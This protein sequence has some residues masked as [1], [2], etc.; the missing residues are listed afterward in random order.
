MLAVCN[1]VNRLI[2]I[3]FNVQ[4]D[5]QS[6]TKEKHDPL[7]KITWIMFRHLY[8][9]LPFVTLHFHLTPYPSTPK[10]NTYHNLISRLIQSTTHAC[11]HIHRKQTSTSIIT[12]DVHMHVAPNTNPHRPHKSFRCNFCLLMLCPHHRGR[13]CSRKGTYL[14]IKNHYLYSILHQVLYPVWQYSV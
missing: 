9:S 7:G 6:I 12:G 13:D 10:L 5:R 4:W 1:N 2:C 14:Y 3:Y 8:S 11:T